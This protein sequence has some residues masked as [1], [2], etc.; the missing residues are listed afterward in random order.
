MSIRRQ[1][2]ADSTKRRAGCGLNGKQR[3]NKQKALAFVLPRQYTTFVL[4]QAV[5]QS[6]R[7]HSFRVAFFGSFL[8]ETRNEQQ[9]K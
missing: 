5:S 4:F 1:L 2:R 6:G 8:G 9:K 7:K 3:R